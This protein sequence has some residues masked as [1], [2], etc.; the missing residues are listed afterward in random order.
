M[1]EIVYFTMMTLYFTG[2]VLL[3]REKWRKELRISY[4]WLNMVLQL[5]MFDTFLSAVWVG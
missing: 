1:K 2:Y 3:N 5:A 4:Y